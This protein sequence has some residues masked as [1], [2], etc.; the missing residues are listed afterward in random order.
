LAVHSAKPSFQRRFQ[1]K[2]IT[3]G[4]HTYC[5][6]RW[7]SHI[8]QSFV[9]GA[10]VAIA[11][12]NHEAVLAR[13]DAP[14]A[15]RPFVVTDPN[16]PI[17]YSDLYKVISTLSIH[18]FRV[19]VLPPVLMLLLAHV[20]EWYNLLP[21]RFPFMRKVL[22]EIKGDAKHLQPGLFSICTHLVASDEDARLPIDKGGLGYA[23]VMTTLQGMVLEVLEWN[24]EHAH[25]NNKVVR[26]PYT[27]SVSLAEKLR[28]LGAVG[29]TVSA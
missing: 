18:S 13:E 11:H 15:G 26:K 6:L 28:K 25:E 5:P 4:T 19:L 12:L 22:P 16:P 24:R 29:I 2:P 9:H 1:T 27:T 8:V 23:G 17:P 3:G 7:A 20:V 10:N 21:Y 14:Q